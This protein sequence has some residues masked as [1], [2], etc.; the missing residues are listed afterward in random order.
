M[1]S[2]DKLTGFEILCAF[3]SICYFNG[4]L[5]TVPVLC[6]KINLVSIP[7][8]GVSALFPSAPF[9]IVLLLPLCRFFNQMG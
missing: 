3:V 9:C 7:F 4:Y 1:E 6:P 2:L 8:L 5:T